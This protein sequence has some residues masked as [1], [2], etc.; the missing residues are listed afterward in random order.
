M[1]SAAHDIAAHQ[2]VPAVCCS[3]HDGA[4]INQPRRLDLL[5]F[6][7]VVIGA[8]TRATCSPTG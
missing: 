7:Y 2:D 4:P 5:D 3:L 8:G 6:D 1:G